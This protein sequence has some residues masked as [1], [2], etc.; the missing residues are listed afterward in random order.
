MR[1][2]KLVFTGILFCPLLSQCGNKNSYQQKYPSNKLA[3]NDPF[4]A[5]MVASEFF[6]I[7]PDQDNIV[8][9]AKGSIIFIPKN[10]LLDENGKPAEGNVKVEL[11]EALS[12]EDMV[13]SNL[14]TTSNGKLLQTGGM[15]YINATANGKPLHID[16]TKPLRIDIPTDIK[17]EGMQAYRGIRDSAGNMNWV[18]PIP[19]IEYLTLVNLDDLDFLPQG[20][21]DTLKNNM[22]YHGHDV[23]NTKLADSVYYSLTGFQYIPAQ[24][25]PIDINEAQH[26][27]YEIKNGQYTKESFNV[28]LGYATQAQQQTDGSK[29]EAAMDSTG[30]CGINPASI[31]VL[32][33]D[34]FAQTFIA[35]REFEA[36]MKHIH[37]TCKQQVLDA[38]VNNIDKN[39]WEADKQAFDI[40]RASNHHK[41][42]DFETFYKQKKGKVKA[43]DGANQKL[44]EYY[45]KKLQETESELNNLRLKKQKLEAAA[46]E[47]FEQVKTQYREIL[48][49]REKYRNQEKYSFTWTDMGWANID[50]GT[51]PKQC[52]VTPKGITITL[53]DNTTYDR[54]YVYALLTSITSL[55]RLNTKD[56][57]TFF[58]GDASTQEMLISCNENITAIAIAYKGTQAYVTQT[59]FFVEQQNNIVI[60]KNLTAV[61]NTELKNLLK[62][63]NSKYNY[64]TE[65]SIEKDLEFQLKIYNE[66][67]RKQA[68]RQEYM[69][70]EKLYRLMCNLCSD[71]HKQALGKRLFNDNCAACHSM[72]NTIIG[73]ALT[74]VTER[75]NMAWLISF[76]R[77]SSEMIMKKDP[78]AVELYNNSNKM[79]MPS[80]DHLS[81]SEIEAIYAYIKPQQC[82]SPV[83]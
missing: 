74:G 33:T 78:L 8:E 19:L 36:R 64:K 53:A 67:Q 35:T 57:K 70:M 17:I 73:P 43:D 41:A 26:N 50:T 45:R 32:K 42:E 11:A 21:F 80:F 15:L 20:F 52:P 29:S 65:N 5:T 49:K 63:H 13:L 68:I 54:V 46:D 30:P 6:D 82:A 39:L 55:S 56:Q 60:S 10:A 22:P 66:N 77:N 72:C 25:A 28:K 14:T 61:S 40:L 83:Q 16:T 38:Y 75:R 34:K 79:S 27:D 24:G 76:T 12:V 1:F 23:A 71:S 48:W 31:K 81:N 18:D 7:K 47:K 44:A 37:Q 4:E 69:L 2:L 3:P 51:V 62:K 9:G 58:A 59:E